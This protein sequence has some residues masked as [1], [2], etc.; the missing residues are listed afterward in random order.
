MTARATGTPDILLAPIEALPQAHQFRRC[1][2]GR[3]QGA[4]RTCSSGIAKA[5]RSVDAVPLIGGVKVHGKAQHVV[6]PVNGSAVGTVVFATADE[7]AKAV[8]IARKGFGIVVACVC[9]DAGQ[10]SRKGS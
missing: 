4:G 7:A 1:R 10:G 6:L 9:G 5:S 3:P 2:A 8:G